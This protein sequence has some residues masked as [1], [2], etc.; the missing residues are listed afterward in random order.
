MTPESAARIAFEA[1]RE[2]DWVSGDY[3]DAHWAVLNGEERETWIASLNSILTFNLPARAAYEMWS[4]YLLERGWRKG[5][6]KKLERREHHWLG[7]WDS[8]SND[9]RFSWTIFSEVA[10]VLRPVVKAG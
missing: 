3:N 7:G 10:K 8:L 6:K 4:K 9:Q 5:E 2:H 1:K